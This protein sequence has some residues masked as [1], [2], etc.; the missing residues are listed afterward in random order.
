MTPYWHTQAIGILASAIVELEAHPHEAKLRRSGTLFEEVQCA[1]EYGPDVP[2][3]IKQLAN[4]AIE[5]DSAL[6]RLTSAILDWNPAFVA[7]L[8]ATQA[9]D[10]ISGGVKVNALPETAS[11]V[12]NHRIAEHRCVALIIH[13]YRE[14]MLRDVV[15]LGSSKRGQPS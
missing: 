1:A 14:Q 4:A 2:A 9:V 11:A 5:D 12:V 8:G 15:P 6:E 7:Q 13:K 10:V 3:H